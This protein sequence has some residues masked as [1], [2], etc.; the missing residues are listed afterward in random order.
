MTLLMFDAKTKYTTDRRPSG[1]MRG[2]AMMKP[3]ASIGGAGAAGI[4]TKSTDSGI[5][6]N[7]VANTGAAV[8]RMVAAAAM[9]T[10]SGRSREASRLHTTPATMTATKPFG[11]AVA[12]QIAEVI[13][14]A[15][16]ERIPISIAGTGSDQSPQAIFGSGSS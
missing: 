3:E 11:H 7:W 5:R 2:C 10:L 6:L 13:P 16:A 8:T 4:E 9:L 12:N 15:R 1:P 14:T